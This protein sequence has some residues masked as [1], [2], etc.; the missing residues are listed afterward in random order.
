MVYNALSAACMA[1]ANIFVGWF[2]KSLIWSVITFALELMSSA[3]ANSSNKPIL[4]V[5][6]TL[7]NPSRFLTSLAISAIAASNLEPSNSSSFSDS[8]KLEFFSRALS[9][10]RSYR[11][12]SSRS[13]W[14]LLFNSLS[15]RFSNLI[16][17]NLTFLPL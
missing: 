11:S 14:F 5:C 9:L 4:D 10:S 7:I 12:N 3:S 2:A 13:F 1:D 8:L 16:S 6:W 17:L 15:L